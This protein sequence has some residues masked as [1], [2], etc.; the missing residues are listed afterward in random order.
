M[1]AALPA[2]V[3]R[4]SHAIGVVVQNDAGILENAVVLP[5][6][7]PIPTVQPAEQTFGTVQEGQ[8]KIDVTVNEGEE[9]ELRFA[10]S[11]PMLRGPGRSEAPWLPIVA[12]RSPGTGDPCPGRPP[13]TA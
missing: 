6:N 2:P 7:T 13:T 11:S 4:S 8:Q 5:A 10:K 1:L 3:D 9:T 12:V